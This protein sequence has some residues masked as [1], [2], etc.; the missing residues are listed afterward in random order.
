MELR[1]EMESTG[2]LH[3]HSTQREQTTS[4]SA[5][6]GRAAL[7]SLEAATDDLVRVGRGECYW[8]MATGDYRLLFRRTEED[9]VRIA[10]LW[11][12]GIATGWEHV[13]WSECAASEWL[14]TVRV[15]MAEAGGAGE[16][17]SGAR[18]PRP[19]G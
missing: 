10:V 15:A 12:N 11:G 4:F 17:G 8:Q 7:A 6:D 2:R 14:V 19:V 5:Y 3:W 13:L 9:T 16:A 18:D 1:L